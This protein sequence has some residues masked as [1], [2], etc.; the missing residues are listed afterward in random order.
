MDYPIQ[1]P[2]IPG[3]YHVRKLVLVRHFDHFCEVEAV[4]FGINRNKD[5]QAWLPFSRHR[6]ESGS[7]SSM[8]PPSC[9]DVTYRGLVT[10]DR[11]DPVIAHEVNLKK[12]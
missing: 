1:W 4:N 10:F 3:I 11:S 8:S 12:L 2:A 6:T 7:L 5:Y 9:P